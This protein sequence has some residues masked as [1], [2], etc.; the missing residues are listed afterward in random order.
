MPKIYLSIGSNIDRNRNI[1]SS[2]RAL[3]ETFGHL[4]LSSTYETAAV[5]FDGPPFFNIVVLFESDLEL[6]RVAEIA[7]EIEIDHGRTQKSSKFSARSLDLDILLYGDLVVNDG[8]IQ[9]PRDDILRYAFV[10]E[11]LAEIAPDETHPITKKK[12]SELWHAY[13]KN[14]L[15]QKIVSVPWSSENVN[16]TS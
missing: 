12:F 2:L 11:P 9:I 6:R 8:R 7:R 3:S 13:N 16:Q 10:L 5:G 1:P 15:D 14:G 4:V